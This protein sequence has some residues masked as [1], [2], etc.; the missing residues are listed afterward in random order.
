M[1][2][3]AETQFDPG[4]QPVEFLRQLREKAS[5]RGIIHYDDQTVGHE[6]V[7]R[8][9]EWD[10]HIELRKA[11]SGDFVVVGISPKGSS[12][13]R[14]GYA[15]DESGVDDMFFEYPPVINIPPAPI[16]LP[17]YLTEEERLRWN[18]DRAV[19]VAQFADQFLKAPKSS[20]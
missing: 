8:G 12:R 7:F 2:E 1:V 6:G 9:N 18:F 4:K 3:N 15:L 17:A 14:E 5:I 19:A 11:R 13:L 10:L 16:D 20:I